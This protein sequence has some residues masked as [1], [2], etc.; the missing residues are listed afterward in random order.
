MALDNCYKIS[1]GNWTWVDAK[2]YCEGFG[3]MMAFPTDEE[4]LVSK[5]K[6]NSKL[7]HLKCFFVFSS[8]I[9]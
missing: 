6:V 8:R 7:F 1:G 9:S 5:C 4:L 2:E 3:A